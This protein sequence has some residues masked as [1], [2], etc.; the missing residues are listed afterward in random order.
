MLNKKNPRLCEEYLKTYKSK[1]ISG[2]ASQSTASN[3]SGSSNGDEYSFHYKKR[4][5]YKGPKES[6]DKNVTTFS[7]INLI[8][9]QLALLEERILLTMRPL[10]ALR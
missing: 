1:Y 10:D 8:E 4:G 9:H 7:L 3:D 6:T 5:S 2:S